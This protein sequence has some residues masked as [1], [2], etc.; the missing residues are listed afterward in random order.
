MLAQTT[1]P[2][3]RKSLRRDVPRVDS[4][5]AHLSAKLRELALLT[6]HALQANGDA[7]PNADGDCSKP[8][9]RSPARHDWL[10]LH[11]QLVQLERAFDAQRL[12]S[13][14]AYVAALRQK[15]ESC[16]V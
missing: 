4:D 3:S 14:S 11:H 10:D 15:V 2:L 1:R 12:D 5:A 13:L 6:Y 16:L 7:Q 8:V 9:L